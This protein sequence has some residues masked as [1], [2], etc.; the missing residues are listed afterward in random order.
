MSKASIE[1]DMRDYGLSYPVSKQKQ[2]NADRI[3]AMPDGE[4]AEFISNSE[5]NCMMFCPDFKAGCL[6]T[7]KHNQGKNFILNWLQSEAE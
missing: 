5:I 7:C 2:T 1:S 4:L 3:R 6:G